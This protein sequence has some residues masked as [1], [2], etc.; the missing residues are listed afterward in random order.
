MKQGQSRNNGM[1]VCF[2]EMK[3]IVTLYLVKTIDQ[4]CCVELQAQDLIAKS[5]RM[6]VVRCNIQKMF[7]CK[8][9]ISDVLVLMLVRVCFLTVVFYS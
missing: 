8:M 9:C 1:A 4:L 2:A 7:H 5:D 6:A 3:I